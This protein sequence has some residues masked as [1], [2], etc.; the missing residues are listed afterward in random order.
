MSGLN[1]AALGR[2][3]PKYVSEDQFTY[4]AHPG[5]ISDHCTPKE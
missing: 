5:R 3:L 1:G 2:L 4:G